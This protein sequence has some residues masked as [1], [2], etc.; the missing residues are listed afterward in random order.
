MELERYRIIYTWK[1]LEG[2]TSNVGIKSYTSTRHGSLCRVPQIKQCASS[3]IRAIREGSLQ[4]RDP[5]MIGVGTWSGYIKVC[6]LL[7]LSNLW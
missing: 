7:T 1:I 4:I 2:I 5:K 3:K 6:A